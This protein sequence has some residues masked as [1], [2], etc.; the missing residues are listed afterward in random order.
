MPLLNSGGVGSTLLDYCKQGMELRTWD[1][2][3]VDVDDALGLDLAVF[4]VSEFGLNL[5]EQP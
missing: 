2:P 1:L 3:G 4:F 5:G